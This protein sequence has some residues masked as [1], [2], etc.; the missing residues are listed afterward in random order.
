MFILIEMSQASQ[1]CH[2]PKGRSFLKEVQAKTSEIRADQRGER[3]GASPADRRPAVSCAL[4]PQVNGGIR[5][6]EGA[7]L[8]ARDKTHR[9]LSS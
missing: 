1:I 3:A 2:R 4:Q 5:G 9:Y 8:K 6:T 7:W